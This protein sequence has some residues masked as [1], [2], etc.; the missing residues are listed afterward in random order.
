VRWKRTGTKRWR[1]WR[2]RKKRR[3]TRG[4]STVPRRGRTAVTGGRGDSNGSGSDS[5]RSGVDGGDLGSRIR[6]HR[7]LGRQ[8]RR[9]LFLFS[10]T[11]QG[12][13]EEK[14]TNGGQGKDNVL[15]GGATMMKTEFTLISSSRVKVGKGTVSTATI[16]ATNTVRGDEGGSKGGGMKTYNQGKASRICGGSRSGN[17]EIAKTNGVVGSVVSDTEGRDFDRS[18]KELIV[19]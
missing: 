2:R 9:R 8:S 18:I 1:D 16:V 3:D 19:M 14:T 6:T 12:A 10:R 13:N 5:V 11:N 15:R 7:E 4:K 17:L